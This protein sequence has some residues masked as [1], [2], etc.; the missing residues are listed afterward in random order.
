MCM[1]SRILATARLSWS[2]FSSVRPSWE[3][4][5]ARRVCL[6]GTAV[7]CISHQ[8]IGICEPELTRSRLV[9]S[10]FMA[11]PG[12][13]ALKCLLIIIIEEMCDP[14]PDQELLRKQILQRRNVAAERRWTPSG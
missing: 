5:G 14:A 3:S 12:V 7:L 2:A 13:I 6:Y 10:H 4:A 8:S 9:A 11:F 1:C